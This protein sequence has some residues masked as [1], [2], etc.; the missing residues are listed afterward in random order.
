MKCVYS[1]TSLQSNLQEIK[2]SYILGVLRGYAS[3]IQPL[4]FYVM[5]WTTDQQLEELL[6]LQSLTS[7][8]LFSN[9]KDLNSLFLLIA[10]TVVVI[11]IAF[12]QFVD[13]ASCVA[14]FEKLNGAYVSTQRFD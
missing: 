10:A 13:D 1:L 6:L 9:K 4:H 2:R 7:E 5:Q 14:A 3:S 12:V 11:S 8:P